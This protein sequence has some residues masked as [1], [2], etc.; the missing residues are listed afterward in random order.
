MPGWLAQNKAVLKPTTILHRAR[1]GHM[2]DIPFFFAIYGSSFDK[3]TC[4]RVVWTG[5]RAVSMMAG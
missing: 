3:P 5:R 1:G 4:P 2:T